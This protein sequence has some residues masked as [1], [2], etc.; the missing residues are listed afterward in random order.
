[1][2]LSVGHGSNPH[3]CLWTDDLQVHGSKRFSYHASRQ[4]VSRC[5]TTGE[6]EWY[7]AAGDKTVK[8]RGICLS[9]DT[10]GINNQMS[11][12]RVSVSTLKKDLLLLCSAWCFCNHK[13]G[14]VYQCF[15]TACKRNTGR[16]VL[17][18]VTIA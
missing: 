13:A 17:L 18:P 11:K 7:I 5:R 1:M 16:F 2:A 4:E 14:H 15:W 12:T 8:K 6:S 10:Q 9:F 3:Q